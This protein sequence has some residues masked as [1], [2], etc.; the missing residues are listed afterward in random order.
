MGLKVIGAGLPRTGTLSLRDAIVRLELGPCY[1]MAEAYERPDS[2]P[3]W[4]R[5]ARGDNRV[6]PEIFAGFESTVDAPGCWFV[7]ELLATYPD[8][9]VILTVRDP[10][11]WL[12]SASETVFS[13]AYLQRLARS[14]FA[15]VTRE[16][17]GKFFSNAGLEQSESPMRGGAVALRAYHAHNANVRRVT[18][19]DQLLIYDV[20]EG[21]EPLCAFLGVA[22]PNDMFPN[23]NQRD[24]FAEQ[25]GRPP[26]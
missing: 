11:H 26:A 22:T 2:W 14:P 6:W 13:P 24:L 10:D 9:L 7:E 19:A 5:A 18:P 25:L 15:S 21:W 20:K 17:G 23:V 4:R 12:Q 1:H 16:M 8:A 3:F